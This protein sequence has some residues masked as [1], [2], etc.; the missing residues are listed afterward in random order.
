ME[1]LLLKA[2]REE[3][4]GQ[5]LWSA[6]FNSDLHKFKLEKQLKALS[7]IVDEKEVGGNDGITIISSLNAS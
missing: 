3:V 5:E 7:N 1:I 4:F 2:L 6:F